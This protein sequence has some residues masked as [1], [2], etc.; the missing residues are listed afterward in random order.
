MIYKAPTSIKNQGAL[1]SEFLAFF[2]MQYF[3]NLF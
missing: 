3:K 1:I 2:V